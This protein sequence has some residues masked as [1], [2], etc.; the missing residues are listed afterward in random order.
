MISGSVG[1]CSAKV[2]T[3]SNDG[4][5]CSTSI[6][7]VA[8]ACRRCAYT[9]ATR[10]HSTRCL[11]CL[12]TA[13]PTRPSAVSALHHQA[14]ISCDYQ[15][16]IGDRCL[17]IATCATVVLPDRYR[18]C[19]ASLPPH[20]AASDRPGDGSLLGYTVHHLYLGGGTCQPARNQSRTRPSSSQD[21]RSID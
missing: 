5:W 21:T 12:P 14:S 17:M 1:E 8:F 7:L 3:S 15:R 2:S 19:T 16:I 9:V 4:S 11:R 13:V 10:R 6:C 20:S 18:P